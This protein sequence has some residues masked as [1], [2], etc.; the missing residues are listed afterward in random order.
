VSPVEREDLRKFV[1]LS[2]T[3]FALLLRW[4]NWWQAAACA[5]AAII[6]NWVVLPAIGADRSLGR[7]GEH[8]VSG[9]KLY[10]I[11][12]LLTILVFHPWMPIAA[13]GWAA[14]GVGDFASNVV[15]RRFGRAK[16][17]WN[18]GKSWVGTL[19]FVVAAAPA[20][21]GLLAFTW[22]N[23]FAGTATLAALLPAACLAALAGALVE[24]IEIPY[25]NDNISVPLTA[26][27]AAY[28]AL[29]LA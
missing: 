17:P 12:V 26:A 20:V 24:T 1:H 4:L 5:G 7:R 11:G 10:P 28:L 3:G 2:M 13:A 27:L 29:P 14:L 15:G 21:A 9:V 22:P 19:A 23:G 18:R 6:L 8:Y 25:V 16:L